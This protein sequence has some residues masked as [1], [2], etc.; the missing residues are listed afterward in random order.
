[1]NKFKVGDI[2]F[3]TTDVNESSDTICETGEPVEV[4]GISS[5]YYEG[6]LNFDGSFGCWNPDHR[7]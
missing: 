7:K 2:V 5:G 4:I 6:W 3:C 1:M